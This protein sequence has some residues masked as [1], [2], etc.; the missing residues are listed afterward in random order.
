MKLAILRPYRYLVLG[1]FVVILIGCSQ[2]T[3]Q[4]VQLGAPNVTAQLTQ[5]LVAGVGW[6]DLRLNQTTLADFLKQFPE[7]NFPINSRQGRYIPVSFRSET[8][9]HIQLYQSEELAFFQASDSECTSDP[10]EADGRADQ[11]LRAWVTRSPACGKLP[12]VYIGAVVT[13]NQADIGELPYPMRTDQGVT[14]LDPETALEVYGSDSLPDDATRG[15]YLG[16]TGYRERDQVRKYVYPDGIMFVV[17]NDWIVEMG[18]FPPV[19]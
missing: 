1:I 17:K 14:L 12:L 7:E 4:V 13:Y 18:I 9:D 5:P 3:R 15:L 8:T 2:V 6:G 11:N 16:G 10:L 19:E